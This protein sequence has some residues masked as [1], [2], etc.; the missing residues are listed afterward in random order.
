MI[1]LTPLKFMRGYKYTTHAVRAAVGLFAIGFLLLASCNKDENTFVSYHRGINAS[2][3][4]VYTQQMMTL[5][6]N[7]YLKS[8]TD[9]ALLE[10]GTTWIDGAR[11]QYS[12]EPVQKIFI[13]YPAWGASDG[14]GHWRMGTYEATTNDGFFETDALIQF[15]FNDFSYDKDTLT[16]DSLV[17]QNLGKTNGQNQHFHFKS[18]DIR[19]DYELEEYFTIFRMDEIFKLIKDPST[20]YTSP[21]DTYEIWGE[22]NGQTDLN[23]LFETQIVQDSSLVNTL[24]CDYLK[25][26]PTTVLAE[27]FGYPSTV[28]FAQVDSCE[29][30]FL[31]EINNNP[32]PFLINE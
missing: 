9:S 6:L 30:R 2:Q 24:S 13:E 3:Q 19:V 20:P 23:V 27:N 26:G 18:G 4:F 16:V 21:N 28:Y 22:L 11:V 8:L 7:T 25:Q 29:N 32:F 12:K 15:T 31:V 10:T 17:L 5:L 14:K 1:L